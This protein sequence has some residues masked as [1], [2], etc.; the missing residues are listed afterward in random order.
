MVVAG[1]A[2]AGDSFT[3]QLEVAAAAVAMEQG[4]PLRRPGEHSHLG[5]HAGLEPGSRPPNSAA[6]PAAVAAAGG[7]GGGR[8]GGRASSLAANVLHLLSAITAIYDSDLQPACG[9]ERVQIHRSAGKERSEKIE[10]RS[11]HGAAHVP[12]AHV[13]VGRNRS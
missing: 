2:E 12:A 4:V 13:P 10:G 11:V 7:G 9:K 6:V 1:G 3:R 5:D 8:G